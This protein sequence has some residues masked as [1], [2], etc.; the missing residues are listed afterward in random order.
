MALIYNGKTGSNRVVVI[1]RQARLTGNAVFDNFLI[2][3][4][5]FCL[6][7]DPYHWVNAILF[8]VPIDCI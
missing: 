5:C 8:Q 6:S 3:F 4:P 2:Y 1:L 7:V